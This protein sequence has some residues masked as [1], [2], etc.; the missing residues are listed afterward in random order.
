MNVEKLARTRT[1][2]TAVLGAGALAVGAISAVASERSHHWGY[3]AGNG[4]ATWS[5]LSSDYAICGSG[6][7]QSPVNIPTDSPMTKTQISTSYAGRPG[8]TVVNNG[9]TI[10]VNVPAGNK[11][12]VNG[13][14]YDLLQ[15]H[16]HTPSENKISG[17]QYPMEMHLVHKSASGALAVI[18][19]MIRRGGKDTLIDKLP[20]PSKAGGRELI[21]SMKVDPSKLLPDQQSHFTFTGSLTTPPCSEGVTWI[22]MS[23]PLH[24]SKKTIARFHRILGNN[25]RPVN[26]LNGRRITYTH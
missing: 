9:H 16:F 3:G 20:T 4:P 19:V 7:R 24:I 6:K 10:Q 13:K 14:T 26:P 1:C 17:V 5:T 11:L 21:T 12:K 23:T 18:A 2:W 8:S 15:F 22:V 25:N